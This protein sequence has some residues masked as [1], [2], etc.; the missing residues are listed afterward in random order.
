MSLSTISRTV[1]A[2]PASSSLFSLPPLPSRFS[3]LATP[4]QS[5]R[6]P[7]LPACDVLAREGSAVCALVH[8]ESKEGEGV[9][10]LLS[11]GIIES[12]RLTGCQGAHHRA[13]EWTCDNDSRGRRTAQASVMASREGMHVL[14]CRRES[15]SRDEK[16]EEAKMNHQFARAASLP[17]LLIRVSLSPLL[18]RFLHSADDDEDGFRFHSLSPCDSQCGG[19]SIREKSR[20][21]SRMS[22]VV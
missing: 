15:P 4:S 5:P 19:S 1:I 10:C 22:H 17:L 12:R 7:G 16:A 2:F 18:P 6:Q 11:R 8:R 9:S 13:S 21:E 14:S 3:S 20:R